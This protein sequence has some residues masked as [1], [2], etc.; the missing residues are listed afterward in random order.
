[1]K[2][3]IVPLSASAPSAGV[4]EA[5]GESMGPKTRPTRPSRLLPAN[6]S[7]PMSGSSSQRTMYLPSQVISSTAP[8]VLMNGIS[9][10]VKNELTG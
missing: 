6:T 4:T 9:D 8:S 2:N 10:S 7:S 1:M 5:Y 3:V